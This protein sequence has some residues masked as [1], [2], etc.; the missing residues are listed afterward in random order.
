MFNPLKN[1]FVTRKMR[2]AIE[3]ATRTIYS[4]EFDFQAAVKL[5]GSTRQNQDLLGVFAACTN[6]K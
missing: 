3:L 2:A 5:L 6:R 1:Y 4:E